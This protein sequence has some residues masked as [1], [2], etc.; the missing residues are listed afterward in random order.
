MRGSGL[1][2]E[3]VMSTLWCVSYAEAMAEGQ[4]FCF[5]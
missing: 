3:T 4:F 1:F 2:P 5:E